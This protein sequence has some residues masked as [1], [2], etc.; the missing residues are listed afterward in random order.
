MIRYDLS[1]QQLIELFGKEHSL[2]P[3]DRGILA[4]IF[5]Y[6]TQAEMKRIIKVLRIAIKGN[7]VKTLH[8]N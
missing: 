6:Q 2:T 5:A 1:L 3:K 7:M 8:E 4:G